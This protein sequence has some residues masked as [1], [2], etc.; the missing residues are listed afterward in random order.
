LGGRKQPRLKEA[1]VDEKAGSAK[2]LRITP[3]QVITKEK[4]SRTRGSWASY[5]W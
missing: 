4:V 2:E 1:K 3:T 5:T